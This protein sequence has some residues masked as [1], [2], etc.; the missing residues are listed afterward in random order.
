MCRN[1]RQRALCVGLVALALALALA[2]VGEDGGWERE[3]RGYIHAI[4]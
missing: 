1:V 4:Q 3:K 2:L